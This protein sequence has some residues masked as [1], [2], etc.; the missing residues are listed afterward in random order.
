MLL[1]IGVAVQVLAWVLV[2]SLGIRLGV[3]GITVLV[4]PVVR[5]LLFDR[6]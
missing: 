1:A 5:V 3:L 4:L 2:P 6:R